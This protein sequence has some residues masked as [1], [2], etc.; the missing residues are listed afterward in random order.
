MPIPSALP[1]RKPLKTA[2]KGTRLNTV[3]HLVTERVLRN[4]VQVIID[5][6]FSRDGVN[7]NIHLYYF[8]DEFLNILLGGKE[9]H[10]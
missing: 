6:V 10:C 4:K 8:V 7:R 5:N 9:C 2:N 3:T 1:G